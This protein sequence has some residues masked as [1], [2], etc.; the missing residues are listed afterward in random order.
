MNLSQT[1]VDL[2]AEQ[3]GCEQKSQR[4]RA[5]GGAYCA[6]HHE[7]WWFENGVSGCKKAVEKARESSEIA[8]CNRA[9]SKFWE[10]RE[11]S[12]P[13]A[14]PEEWTFEG[15]DYEVGIFTDEIYHNPCVSDEGDVAEAVEQQTN[16]RD[17]PTKDWA[18]QITRTWECSECGATTSA[19]TEEPKD[20][21]QEE[22]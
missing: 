2:I 19:V 22:R 7:N 4:A 10:D 1:T 21:F 18:V 9:E 15:P 3:L 16:I 6:T 12:R 8:A 20:H 11:G 5:G 14:E 13:D 17:H